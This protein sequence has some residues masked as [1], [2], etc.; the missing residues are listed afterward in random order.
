MKDQAMEDKII[1]TN[2]KG[3]RRKYGNKGFAT[4]PQGAR[5]IER[6]R[7][8]RGIKSRVVFLTARQL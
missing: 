6:G 7:K 1:V 5:R 2:R 3:L 4:D 8:K